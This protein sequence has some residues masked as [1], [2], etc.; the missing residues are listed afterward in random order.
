MA[1]SAT[2]PMDVASI[3]APEKAVDAMAAMAHQGKRLQGIPKFSSHAERRQWQLEHMAGA[4]RVFSREGYTEGISGHISVRDP[5][6]EDRFWI[7]PLGVH[8]GLLKAS[9]M[10]CVNLGGEV[11][12]GNTEGSINAAGFQIH[13]AVHRSRNDV[14]AIC[15][16]HSVHGRAWSAFAKPL[17]MINQDV[18]YFYKAHSVYS[19]YGGIANGSDEGERIA[20]SLG[21]GKAVI[22]KNHGLLTVGETVDEAAFLFC[23]MERSCKVQLL[24]D[25]AGHEKHIVSDS[26]AAY[27]FEMASTPETLYTEFQPHYQYEEAMANISFK[28]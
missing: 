2:A 10:I 12:G 23:L 1:P 24:A 8:F 13:S 26:E 16:T 11:V 5:E 28:S 17:E 7:N 25:T 6:F 22:L 15:H 19:S 27:N 20:R 18:C 14:H 9:D 21:D 3:S 4:F